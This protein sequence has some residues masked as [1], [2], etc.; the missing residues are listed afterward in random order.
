MRPVTRGLRPERLAPALALA[1]ALAAPQAL[2]QDEEGEDAEEE[3]IEQI[4]EERAREERTDGEPE[5]ANLGEASYNVADCEPVNDELAEDEGGGTV[6]MAE[7]G[8]AA[9]PSVDTKELDPCRAVQP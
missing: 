8:E 3:V 1:L 9:D 5:D 2:A 7:S 6:A 4:V